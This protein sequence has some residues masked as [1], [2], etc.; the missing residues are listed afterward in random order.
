MTTSPR[1]GK[2]GPSSPRSLE[3]STSITSSTTISAATIAPPRTEV[4]KARAATAGPKKSPAAKTAY[5]ANTTASVMNEVPIQAVCV[6]DH[7]QEAE[8]GTKPGQQDRR[9]GRPELAPPERTDVPGAHGPQQPAGAQ[10]DRRQPRGNPP[11][12]EQ[13]TRDGTQGEVGRIEGHQRVEVEDGRGG[14]RHEDHVADHDDGQLPARGV[15]VRRD[16]QREMG[17]APDGKCGG[18]VLDGSPDSPG[19]SRRG[20]PLQ[21]DA[22]APRRDHE[23]QEREH[24]GDREPGARGDGEPEPDG[25]QRGQG[26]RHHLEPLRHVHPGPLANPPGR[27]L[28][29]NGAAAIGRA[30]TVRLSREL[31]TGGFVRRHRPGRPARRHFPLR[32]STGTI[33]APWRPCSISSRTA[34]DGTGTATRWASAV[35]TAPRSTGATRRC[36]AAAALRPGACVH[37]DSHPA[38]VS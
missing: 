38:T 4:R 37:S 12:E 24:A 2:K 7:G 16:R 13:L 6:P 35:T 5:D 19:V 11:P 8:A 34:P 22:A 36:C 3:L 23:G 20:Q 30:Q 31:R 14:E 27:C 15:A 29:T 17:Q 28:M 26:L 32:G 1:T 9:Q 25:Q 18:D 33:A 21:D 10:Q